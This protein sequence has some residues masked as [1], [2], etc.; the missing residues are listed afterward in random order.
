MK[1][2]IDSIA[3]LTFNR[4]ERTVDTFLLQCR[5]IKHSVKNETPSKL[6]E[7]RILRSNMRCLEFAE[8]TYHRGDELP[9][10]M[11]ILTESIGKSMVQILD[12]N[13]SSTQNQ[14]VD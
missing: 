10:V 8:F 12:T 2:A 9:P 4:F 5:D 7:A 1:T 6:L 13:E 14:H 3:A 11:G